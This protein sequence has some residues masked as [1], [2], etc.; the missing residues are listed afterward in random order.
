MPI[1]P[2]ALKEDF[3]GIE[4]PFII[5]ISRTCRSVEH[6]TVYNQHNVIQV[7]VHRAI[8][9]SDPVLFSNVC[10]DI[11]LLL[12]ESAKEVEKALQSCI[13]R[14][15]E[16]LPKYSVSRSLHYVCDHC[17]TSSELHYLTPEKYH[18]SDLEITCVRNQ[19]YQPLTEKEKVWF[20]KEVCI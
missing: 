5:K 10:Q 3:I 9:R 2:Y 17:L 7:N 6:L 11:L 15:F 18:T 20:P 14:G 12:E 16:E 13:G 8:S 4:L 19:K 1:S